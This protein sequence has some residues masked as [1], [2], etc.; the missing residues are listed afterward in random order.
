MREDGGATPLSRDPRALRRGRRPR[1]P[2]TGWPRSRCD[3]SARSS[4]SRRCRS[5]T[6]SPT[7]TTCSTPWSRR[8]ARTSTPRSAPAAA[9]AAEQDWARPCAAR[10]LAARAV[11]LQHRWLPA[12]LETR[13]V[14]EP[15]DHRLRRGRA[16]HPARRRLLLRPGPPHAARARAAGRSGSA[17]SCSTRRPGRGLGQTRRPGRDGRPLPAPGG[18]DGGHRPRRP[19]RRRSD[20]ATT[21]PSSSSVSTCCSTASSGVAPGRR[22]NRRSRP[23]V[24]LLE[25]HP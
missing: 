11:M 16:R 25:H 24:G 8:S 9:T 19:R 15:L 23:V 10:L 22:S 20:G 18:D 21:R 2:T 7:R 12:L 1:R 13:L 3:A 4:G 17:R 6:T 14:D 5:T